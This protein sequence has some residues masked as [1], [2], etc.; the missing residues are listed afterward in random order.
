MMT[1]DLLRTGN[2]AVVVYNAPTATP[3]KLKSLFRITGDLNCISLRG[4]HRRNRRA[5][6]SYSRNKL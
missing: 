1:G 6:Y 4:A 2:E 3:R 5:T